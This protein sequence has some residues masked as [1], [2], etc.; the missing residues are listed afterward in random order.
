VD[1]VIHLTGAIEWTG[2]ILAMELAAILS[3]SLYGGVK[4]YERAEKYKKFGKL[5]LCNRDKSV[6]ELWEMTEKWWRSFE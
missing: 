2:W 6:E 3:V 5:A 1:I 4:A